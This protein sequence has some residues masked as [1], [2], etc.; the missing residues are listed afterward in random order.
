VRAQVLRA[1][2]ATAS[3]KSQDGFGLRSP[4]LSALLA[5]KAAGTI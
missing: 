2:C 4:D 3:R 5:E 1:L